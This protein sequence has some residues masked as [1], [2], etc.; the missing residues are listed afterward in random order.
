M[1]SRKD[2]EAEERLVLSRHACLAEE[3]R[4]RAEDEPQCPYRT[5]FQRDTD[6][7]MATDS[8]LWQLRNAESPMCVTE[9]GISTEVRE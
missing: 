5:V 4:G 8:R 3:S 9:S 2:L 7:G 6:E 1:R